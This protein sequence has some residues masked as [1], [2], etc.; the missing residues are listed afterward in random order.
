MEMVARVDKNT[1]RTI[2]CLLPLLV[3]WVRADIY[4]ASITAFPS[5]TQAENN[6]DILVAV[7]AFFRQTTTIELE[8][9]ALQNRRACLIACPRESGTIRGVS[10]LRRPSCHRRLCRWYE[11][12]YTSRGSKALLRSGLLFW[13]LIPLTHKCCS[14]GSESPGHLLA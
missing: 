7:S 2:L 9:Q 3:C 12:P 13:I 10:R 14:T 11:R 5:V 8:L 4:L 1:P 6:Y